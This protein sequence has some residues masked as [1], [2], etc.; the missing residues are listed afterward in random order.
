[1]LTSVTFEAKLPVDIVI[2]LVHKKRDLP[3]K[4]TVILPFV[5]VFSAGWSACE[6]PGRPSGNIS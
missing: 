5:F 4:L 6:V 1:M 2:S 3:G